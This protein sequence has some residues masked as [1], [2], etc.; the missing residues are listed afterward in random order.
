MNLFDTSLRM[1]PECGFRTAAT[2][3][4]SDRTTTVV[5]RHY[6]PTA[7]VR[8]GDVVGDRYQIASVLGEGGYSTVFRGQHVITGQEVAIKVLKATWPGPDEQAVRRFYREARVTAGLAH[9]NTIRVFDVGQTEGGSFWL[10]MELLRGP[11][12]EDRLQERW[13]GQGG[14]KGVLSESECIAMAVPVLRSLHEAHQRKLV[15][16]DLKPAN[17]VL[18]EVAGESLVKVLDFGIAQTSGSTLTTTGMALGTPAY[19]SPEQCQGLDL[20]GRSDLYSLGIVLYRCVSGDVPFADLN[21]VKL[22]QAHLS[23]PLPDLWRAARTK[24]SQGFVDTVNRALAKDKGQRF[25]DAQQM[26]EALLEAGSDLSKTAMEMQVFR[27]D[28]KPP[29]PRQRRTAPVAEPAAAFAPP[30]LPPRPAPESRPART[31]DSSMPPPLPQVQ[32]WADAE[33]IDEKGQG[34]QV[35]APTALP[36]LAAESVQAG[37]RAGRESSGVEPTKRSFRTTMPM[38]GGPLRVDSPEDGEKKPL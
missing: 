22:M 1:C 30:P 5:L 3:C 14:A 21:P 37:G 26:R 29:P 28:G 4:P 9:P 25:A 27:T 8:T 20:D 19:M 11:S 18:A 6:V 35:H 15:H 17:I 38:H 10:A 12:L 33:E 24:L 31:A 2:L 32:H 34:V 16:R 23:R 7:Q 13:S 36:V